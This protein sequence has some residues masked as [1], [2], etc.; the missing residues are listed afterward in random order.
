MRRFVSHKAASDTAIDIEDSLQPPLGFPAVMLSNGAAGLNADMDEDKTQAPPPDD[1]CWLGTAPTRST[2][3]SMTASAVTDS[4]RRRADASPGSASRIQ[5][6]QR[7][8]KLSDISE[9]EED[10]LQSNEEDI[11]DIED[12]DEAGAASCARAILHNT[13]YALVAWLIHA[14]YALT[15]TV[16][17]KQRSLT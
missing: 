16:A 8:P 1:S 10:D 4:K 12:E 2:T 14:I 3:R 6:T 7:G 5:S 13:I 11:E 15:L 9:E 17:A